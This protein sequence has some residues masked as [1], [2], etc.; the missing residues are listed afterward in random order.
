MDKTNELSDQFINI[1]E[2]KLPTHS[3]ELSQAEEIIHKLKVKVAEIV[4]S[5]CITCKMHETVYEDIIIIL[6][7]VGKLS[8]PAFDIE[9]ELEAM[10]VLKFPHSPE[11]AKKLWSDHYEAIHHPYTLLKNR[12]YRMLDELDMAYQ[13]KYKKNPPNWEV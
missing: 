9:D 8:I 4:Y 11:L 7:K 1:D 2:F 13:D 12:C 5:K 6:D 3:N 10:Y